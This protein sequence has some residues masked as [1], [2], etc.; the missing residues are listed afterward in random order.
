VRSFPVFASLA[1]LGLGSVLFAASALADEPLKAPGIDWDTR[2][3]KWFTAPKEDEAARKAQMKEA[4][5]ALKRPCKFCHT[6]DFSGFTD[7]K[8]KLL[9]QQ[10]MIVS[11]ENGVECKDCHD[12]REKMTELGNDAKKMYDLARE[13]NVFCDECH[14]PNKSKFKDLTD[15]GKKFKEEAEAKS[16]GAAPA[17]AAPAPAPATK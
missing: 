1:G 5:R 16:K 7:D 2:A 13:K 10:M 9:T 17:S 14:Q 8:R 12:G 3:D 4:S 15:K 6:E 11:A